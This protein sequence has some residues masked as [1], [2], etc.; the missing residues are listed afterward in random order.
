MGVS[1][2]RAAPHRSF[3]AR[4]KAKYYSSPMGVVSTVHG[5]TAMVVQGLCKATPLSLVTFQAGGTG[6]VTDMR[7]DGS[8][9]V[10]LVTGSVAARET[11]ISDG[12][13]ITIPLSHGIWGRVI[14][15][16]GQPI[17]G[18][19]AIRGNEAA[20]RQQ[21]VVA[22][23]TP[24]ITDRAA[25]SASLPFGLK[26][27]DAH[28]PLLRG[29]SLALL[30][31]AGGNAGQLLALQLVENI[32]AVNDALMREGGS[33]GIVKMVYVASGSGGG[34][35]KDL[36]RR[37]RSSGAARYTTVVAAPSTA[38][39][40]GARWLAPLTGAAIADWVSSSGGHALVIYDS[41][42]DHDAVSAAGRPRDPAP[43]SL[44]GP[45]L[46]RCAQLAPANGGGSHSALVLVSEPASGA[47]PAADTASARDSAY[48]IA[49]LAGAAVKLMP[50]SGGDGGGPVVPVAFES[51]PA[52][53]GHA[54]Q[55]RAIRHYVTRCG[56]ALAQLS[57]TARNVALAGRY[58]VEPEAEA[59]VSMDLHAKARAL[60]NPAADVLQALREAEQ[61]QAAA[62]AEAAAAAAA[63]SET[64]SVSS[65]NTSTTPPPPPVSDFSPSAIHRLALTGLDYLRREGHKHSGSSSSGSR[66]QDQA[67]LEQPAAPAAAAPPIQPPSP[68]SSTSLTRRSALLSRLDSSQLEFVKSRSAGSANSSGG[69]S[70]SRIPKIAPG[71]KSGQANSVQQLLQA[72]S[73][74]A[75]DGISGNNSSTSSAVRLPFRPPA[76]RS[77]PEQ[78]F[79]DAAATPLGGAAEAGKANAA[80][81]SS[82]SGS[83]KELSS[84]AA[85][86]PH[87]GG[88]GRILLTL[89]LIGHGYPS[90]VPL[91][92]L[93]SWEQGL[94]T[95]LSSLPASGGLVTAARQA[96]AALA[97]ED[98]Q[99]ERG[100]AAASPQAVMGGGFYRPQSST[101]CGAPSL[102]D[103]CLSLPPPAL[104][105]D[106]N[107]SL[108]I[109]AQLRQALHSRAMRARQ[110]FDEVSDEQE[111][112]EEE[113]TVAAVEGGE[114][115]GFFSWLMGKAKRKPAPT[116][117]APVASSSSTAVDSPQQPSNS[118]ESSASPS[119]SASDSASPPSS[120]PELPWDREPPSSDSD[121]DAKTAVL[122]SGEF[123][124]SPLASLYSSSNGLSN[125]S[126]SSGSSSAWELADWL[127]LP[128]EEVEAL[129]A[130]TTSA[131]Q[132]GGNGAEASPAAIPSTTS[133]SQALAGSVW[134][135]LHLATAQFT[136]D[137][138]EASGRGGSSS[139]V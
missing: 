1:A 47:V 71:P 129:L 118:S 104:P 100:A 81:A 61:Q 45:I 38:S 87:K 103:L 42:S 70:G 108:D 16:L 10:E 112:E 24:G 101:A 2:G 44:V 125:S 33:D 84:L 122:G 3:S 58:G 5:E 74:D 52:Q 55:G 130:T 17:D 21:P 43:P 53:S 97:A 88:P 85:L 37:L 36:I 86:S 13:P 35:V 111:D 72:E 110:E 83:A 57:E 99:T 120:G 106:G 22:A 46:D 109:P 113:V 138:M 51:L 134:A 90:L 69:S 56:V 18:K 76:G 126:S 98:A 105:S 54:A 19:G 79:A 102:L 115:V 123:K 40:S 128:P 27:M 94:Y 12:S 62:E 89:F 121:S 63:A 66:N 132:D 6:I 50:R 31:Q 96:A 114:K 41:L 39:H 68:P 7:S 119:A 14:D 9:T 65:T 139:R 117:A 75:A 59:D 80:V 23:A 25:L 29:G 107:A 82:S 34:A 127:M 136:R 77:P 133:R 60:L 93:L 91:S 32:T 67:S 49:S 73:P 15:P 124:P 116:A 92:R 135:A 26:T 137:F 131:A 95:T 30:G 64:S 48:H 11:A 78:A 28:H 20:V 4:V 8:I